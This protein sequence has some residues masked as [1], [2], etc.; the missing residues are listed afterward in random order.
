MNLTHSRL[1]IFLTALLAI[2][3]SL[4]LHSRSPVVREW[5]VAHESQPD[6]KIAVFADFHFSTQSDLEQLG[7]LKRQIIREQPD[8][9]LLA[10]DFIGAQSF[11]EN[12]SR[13]TIVRALEALTHPF[14]TYAVLG[15]H[16]DWDSRDQWISA[17]NDSKIQLV[18]NSVLQTLINNKTICIRGLG[19]FY[20]SAWKDTPI[21]V[22][23]GGS[24]ITL[25]HDPQGL[26]ESKGT[27]ESFS[28]AGHTHCGQIA[29]PLIGA[30]VVPTTAPRDMHC[31]Q[32]KK[33]YT[34]I[35]S[36]GLGTS[37]IPLRW[38]PN[39]EPGWEIIQIKHLKQP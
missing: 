23:C 5:L 35:T 38:G 25:T 6:M 1:L 20:S 30:P 34:G 37:I 7:Q 31:G 24:T 19:D 15:N 36:G 22:N 4:G 33:R 3:I 17:F 18:E 13:G 2:F 11:Y 8:I 10:G 27:L 32:Y 16:D 12:T 39:T 14:Q 21:P 9:V 26:L 28:V 29:F